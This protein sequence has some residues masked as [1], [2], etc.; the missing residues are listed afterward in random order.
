VGKNVE[1]KARV[2]D[3]EALRETIL[4]LV[5]QQARPVLIQT[6]TYFKIDRGRLKLRENSGADGRCEL[7]SYS[8]P[9]TPMPCL[10]QY[11]IFPVK[12][13]EVVKQELS[14]SLG[15][16][17]V[18]R[19]AREV[20]LYENVRIHLDVVDGLGAFLEL[21]AVIPA[22]TTEQSGEKM[23]NEL[24]SALRIESESLVDVS[25]CDLVERLG[26]SDQPRVTP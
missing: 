11:D 21:E 13:P 5:P 3:V 7:I 9:V 18:V 16:R 10:S 26:M 6:D 1:I 14:E 20:Y 2:A 17:S 22:G 4:R 8:R 24:L 23:V 15:I 19:K 12:N 25:Y